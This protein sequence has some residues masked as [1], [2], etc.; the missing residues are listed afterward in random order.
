[1]SL[2]IEASVTNSSPANFSPKQSYLKTV[3]IIWI[4]KQAS[5]V[6]ALLLS[7]N[8]N[9]KGFAIFFI[10]WKI[11]GKSTSSYVKSID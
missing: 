2:K 10:K 9:A 7:V 1:M 5:F 4:A 6:I 11:Y 3:A 8:C